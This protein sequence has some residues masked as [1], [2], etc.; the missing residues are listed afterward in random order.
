[1]E[2]QEVIGLYP[3]RPNEAG[4]PR[5]VIEL[6]GGSQRIGRGSVED[7]VKAMRRDV[8]RSLLPDQG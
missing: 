1:M 7:F 4:I 2:S 5:T 8:N 3:L 6:R